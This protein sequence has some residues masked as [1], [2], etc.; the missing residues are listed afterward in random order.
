LES[1]EQVL[2][3]HVSEPTV[4]LYKLHSVSYLPNVTLIP[5]LRRI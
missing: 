4:D 3:H 1:S 2:T 5:P